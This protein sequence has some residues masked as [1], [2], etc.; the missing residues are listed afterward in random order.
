MI[1]KYG[2]NNLSRTQIKNR[3]KKFVKK[4]CNLI[5]E[6]DFCNI[7][8]YNFR[9]E[10]IYINVDEQIGKNEQIAL[11]FFQKITQT[12]HS[13]FLYSFLH[14]IGHFLDDSFSNHQSYNEKKLK[15]YRE[16]KIIIETALR[17]NLISYEEALEL[18]YEEETETKANEYMISLIN[19]FPK[20]IKIFN[21]F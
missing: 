3:C 8:Y 17:E 5:P 15:E 14:E 18:Y 6:V 11:D 10:K 21:T 1:K 4:T 9:E 2:Q 20:E 12:N 16:Y 7:W 13:L 19:N